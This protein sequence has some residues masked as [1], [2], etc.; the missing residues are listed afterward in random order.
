MKNIAILVYAIVLMIIVVR[1]TLKGK[2]LTL[3]QMQ[4]FIM[5]VAFGVLIILGEWAG[6]LGVR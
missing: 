1:I 2:I 6:K 4:G 5:Y 3:E